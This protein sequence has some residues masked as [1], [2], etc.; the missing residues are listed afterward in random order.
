[1]DIRIC[2]YLSASFLLE[3]EPL[4][5]DALVVLDAKVIATDFVQSHTRKHLFLRFD[6]IERPT[7][8]RRLVTSDQLARGLEFAKDSS[9]LLISCR[10][11]QS[12]SAALAYLIACR[13]L[14]VDAAQKMIDPKRHVPNRL[15]VSLG[16][17][18]LDVP[19]VL[20]AFHRWREA[21]RR[22]VLSD[23]YDEIEREFDDLVARGA[24]DRIVAT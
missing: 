5:W 21:H 22:I 7:G 9:R 3:H 20:D 13:D 12:R 11:G 14:G 15:V 2:G 18:L 19:D 16:A 24:V 17:A 10:A 23:Y 4:K 6:D 1:M 8:N